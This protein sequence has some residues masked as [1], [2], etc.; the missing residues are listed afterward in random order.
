M[1]TQGRHEHSL[2][3]VSGE[4]PALLRSRAEAAPPRVLADLGA[5]EGAVLYALDRAGLVGERIY[6]VDLSERSLAVA[7]KLSEK[8]VPVVSDV[9]RVEAI[10]DGSVDAVTSSQVIEHLPDDRALAA[11]IARILRPGGWFYVSTVL[12]GPHAWWF[13]RGPL[14]WQIDP[15]HLREYAS[16]DTFAAALEHPELELDE[17]VSRPLRFPVADPLLRLASSA[18]LVPA[19]RLAAAYE[20]SGALA[21]LRRRVQLRVP[22]YRWVEATGRRRPSP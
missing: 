17:V 8:V 9:V 19:E 14:G 11:E 2:Y 15:T 18:R 3:F 10:P 20:R 7:S 4:M 21:A 12:R 13:R 6:A 16:E 22:G 5:G 1:T